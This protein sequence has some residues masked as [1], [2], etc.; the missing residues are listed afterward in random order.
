MHRDRLVQTRQSGHGRARGIISNRASGRR[1]QARSYEPCPALSPYVASLWSGSWD[2]QGQAPHESRLLSDPCMHLVFE[3][4]DQASSRI[5]G[6]WTKL[7]TR[8]LAGRGRVRGVKLRPGAG[9]AFI[10]TPAHAL[11]NRMMPLQGAMPGARAVAQ[12]VRGVNDA[13]AF[14]AIEAWLIAR[15][16]TD[17]AHDIELAIRA[18]ERARADASLTRVERLADAMGL[19]VRDLQRLFRQH[20]GA[21]PKW[22]I[23]WNRLQEVALQI[24]RGAGQTRTLAELAA[25]LGYTDQA[26]LNRDFK[27]ATGQS[28]SDF[29][30]S[31][32]PGT[33][34]P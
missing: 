18:V 16:R 32:D 13:E 31:A 12:A 30:V 17:D 20:V 2:L 7:W 22:V 3:E 21:T 6:V 23:R 4:G 19:G 9:Q 34:E 25:E 10:E 8:T 24:E 14:A 1:V 28:P 15:L 11:R 5:V 33:R 26:H 27:S 29:R